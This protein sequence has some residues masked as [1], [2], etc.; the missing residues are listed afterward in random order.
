MNDMTFNVPLTLGRVKTL[1]HI[2]NEDYLK[3]LI[4]KENFI[5]KKKL[6]FTS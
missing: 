5:G 6:K 4:R 2:N 1:F 3:A